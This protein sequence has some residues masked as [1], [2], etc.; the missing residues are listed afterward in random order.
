MATLDPDPLSDLSHADALAMLAWQIDMGADEALLDAPL[1]RFALAEQ[2]A[3]G[4]KPENT[5]KPAR[6]AAPPAAA[7][8]APPPAAGKTA[9]QAV[10]TARLAAAAAQDLAGLRAAM[11]A[12]E[13]CALRAS[14]RNFVFCDG[15]PQARVMIVGEAPG[16]DE[17]LQGKPFVGRAGQLLD[18][19]FGAIGLSRAAEAP[20]TGL[21]ITNLLPWR[22]PQNRDPRPEEIA[23][24]GHFLH[25]HVELIDPAFLILMGNYACKALLGRQGISRLRGTWAEAAGRP[26]LP[27]FHPAYLLRK[28]HEKAKAWAD[29]LSLQAK[30]TALEQNA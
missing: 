6:V 1:D 3:R 10:E 22:P 19:M 30:F 25:R 14:A 23:I 21:Y 12:F 29:L 2:E 5:P 15:M 13:P 27:M 4:T 8:V 16:R 11:E 18:R 26:A 9:D 24:Y 7:A 28:P 20:E 17:D